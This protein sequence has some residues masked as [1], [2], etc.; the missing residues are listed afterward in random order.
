MPAKPVREV[1]SGLAQTVTSWVGSGVASVLVVLVVAGWLVL[2]IFAGFSEHWHVWA[3]TVAALVTL[4]MV[5]VIQH[6]T[7]QE[8]RAMLV[9]L[10]ELLRAHEGARSEI[11]AVEKA[12]LAKLEEIDREMDE[13]PHS[14]PNR[15]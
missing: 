5:F 6:T 9:K 7:N 14:A 11:M 15:D 1:I 2:G 13:H 4:M 3:H 12:D 10:D 8:S